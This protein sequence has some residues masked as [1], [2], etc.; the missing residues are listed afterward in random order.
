MWKTSVWLASVVVVFALLA[1]AITLAT[2]QAATAAQSQARETLALRTSAVNTALARADVLD[3]A[4]YVSKDAPILPQE[5]A[6]LQVVSTTKATPDDGKEYTAATWSP[7]SDAVLFTA[8]TNEVRAIAEWDAAS[9][10]EA[11]PVAVSKNELILHPLKRNTWEQVTQDGARPV[12]STDGRSL[13]YMVGTELMRADL[14]T[15]TTVSTGHHSPNTSVGLLLSQPLPNGNL[16]APAQAHAPLTVQGEQATSSAQIGVAENDNVSVSPAGNQTV[17]AYGATTQN[18]KAVPAIAELRRADGTTTPLL[19]NCQDSALQM[20]WSSDGTRIAYPLRA[21]QPEIRIYDVASGKTRVLVRL[22]TFDRLSNLA[23]SPDG[24]YL[25]YVQ[26]DGRDAPRS[27]W[28][29]ALNGKQRQRLGEGLLPAWS[30]DGRYIAYAQPGT[31][32][33]LDWYVMDVQLQGGQ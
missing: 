6:F 5:Q 9:G 27:L 21:E 30:P 18:G 15:K 3:C 10:N 17:V 25:A 19:K 28:V 26:G 24:K 2:G 31:G 32:R 12:W 23:W 20:A 16:L 13:F 11:Q 1:A 33:L 14:T 4:T 22:D 29:V 7:S 8:P